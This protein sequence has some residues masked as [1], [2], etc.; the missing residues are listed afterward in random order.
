M[1]TMRLKEVWMIMLIILALPSWLTGTAANAGGTA[2]HR[3]T[4]R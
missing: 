2:S 3:P 4:P 1:N